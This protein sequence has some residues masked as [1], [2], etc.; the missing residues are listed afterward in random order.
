MMTLFRPGSRLNNIVNALGILEN[1]YLID[2]T[3]RRVLQHTY[4]QHGGF[5]AALEEKE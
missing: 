5:F 1:V 3:V 4:T 2:K